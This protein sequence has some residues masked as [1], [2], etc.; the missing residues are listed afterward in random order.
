MCYPERKL[1]VICNSKATIIVLISAKAYIYFKKIQ[2]LKVHL[3][4]KCDFWTS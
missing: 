3:A 4:E 1:S 2:A